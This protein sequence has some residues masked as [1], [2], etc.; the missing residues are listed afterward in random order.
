[1]KKIS[2]R[3]VLIFCGILS[4]LFVLHPKEASAASN[5]PTKVRCGVGAI[6]ESNFTIAHKKN[7]KIKN[8][9]SKSKY[10]KV[11]LQK[12]DAYQTE[13]D[14]Y[15]LKSGT[16]KLTFDKYK[17]NKKQRSY[18]VTVYAQKTIN[19]V[20]KSISF[21]GK[22][23]TSNVINQKGNIQYYPGQTSGKIKIE[24]ANKMKIKKITVSKLN[25]N[26]ESETKTVKNG[27]KISFGQYGLSRKYSD[28][29]EDE[30][31][32]SKEP[33]AET[34]ISIQ[35][36]DT[37]TNETFYTFVSVWIPATKWVEEQ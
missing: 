7:E 21:N 3:S 8:L 29:E 2:K 4:I 14:F 9:K 36:K 32:W 28:D 13:I 11:S 31:Q 34:V 33:L 25:S 20:V 1:M 37:L 35:Y 27:S 26:G 12:I 18:T 19:G 24:L 16:Y 22:K 10:L 30:Y 5:V 17:S 6:G 15:C 23:V